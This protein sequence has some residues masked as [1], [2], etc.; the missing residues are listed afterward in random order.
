VLTEL[1]ARKGYKAF[2]DSPVLQVPKVS[3][4]LQAQPV[5]KASRV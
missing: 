5:L 2:K 3:K 4:V 1:K